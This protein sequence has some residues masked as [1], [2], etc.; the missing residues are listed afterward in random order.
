MNHEIIYKTHA[1]S[2]DRGRCMECGQDTLTHLWMC[3]CGTASGN[4][5]CGLNMD[6]HKKQYDTERTTE[7]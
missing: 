6:N 1:P 5:D 2:D 7:A 3:I 4:G